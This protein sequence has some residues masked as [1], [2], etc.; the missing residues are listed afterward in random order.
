MNGNKKGTVLFVLNPHYGPA[1]ARIRGTIY[2]QVLSRHGWQIN[3]AAISTSSSS[4]EFDVYRKTEEEIIRLASDCDIVYLIKVNSYRFIKKIR[5]KTRAKL[6]FDLTD[7]LW[8]RNFR[9]GWIFL[10]E[11]LQICDAVFSENEYVCEYGRKYNDHV[12]SLPAC[13]QTEKF[14]RLRKRIERR[15]DD[16]IILGWIGSEPTI[17]A[18][19][20]IL[21]PLR[22]L[23]AKYPN[24]ELRILGS[25]DSKLKTR[26]KEIR[27]SV[28]CHYS[29]EEMMQEALA[30]DIGL[31][32]PPG[33]IVD[34]RIRGALK[35]MIYMSAGIP[36]V[37][38]NAG[39]S[40]KIIT[41]GM[42]GMLVS[43]QS[44]WEQKIEKLIVDADL[45]KGIGQLAYQSIKKDHSLETVGS[46]LSKALS[47][48]LALERME[49]GNISLLKKMKII[50]CTLLPE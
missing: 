2:E 36:A 6:I 27:Y 37:C 14:D 35:A 19:Y 39:D 13:T 15:N 3:Y 33:D 5:K 44:Q 4:P 50:S 24:L 16:K 17:T 23:F 45:R 20:S 10:E 22:N 46:E 28:L 9:K 48:V 18:I 47:A 41:D 38:F 26:L 42:N 29:E 49:K 7:A 43:E 32:P 8:R 21:K 25:S 34:Y 11:I 30:M 40:A 31:F 1:T 12:F